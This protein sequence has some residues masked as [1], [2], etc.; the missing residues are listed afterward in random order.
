MLG[1]TFPIL[2]LRSSRYQLFPISEFLDKK[3]KISANFSR[4]YLEAR[5]KVFKL[6]I[7]FLGNIAPNLI[8][9]GCNLDGVLLFNSFNKCIFCHLALLHLHTAQKILILA[10]AVKVVT[11]MSLLFISSIKLLPLLRSVTK[12]KSITSRSN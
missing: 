4:P 11:T 2:P 8:A 6:T 5:F 10:K 1:H 7:S 12:D 3:I 9:T